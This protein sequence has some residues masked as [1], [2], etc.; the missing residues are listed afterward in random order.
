MTAESLAC[1]ARAAVSPASLADAED[2]KGSSALRC[3][4]ESQ[5]YDGFHVTG[6]AEADVAALAERCGKA[7]GMTA[8]TEPEEGSSSED[9]PPRVYAI[10]LDPARCYRIFAV[11]DPGVRV[12]AAAIA[13]RSGNVV[14][15][16]NSRDRAPILGPR[17]AFCPRLGGEHRLVVS[18]VR[19]EGR[20]VVQI[21]SRPRE[22]REHDEP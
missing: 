22:A 17:S 5:C 9:A 6:D 13:D 15:I 11:G 3:E 2:A 16:D 7:C 20:Y 18:A 8:R 14:A 10:D 19:G 12:L 1:A 21:W 4:A